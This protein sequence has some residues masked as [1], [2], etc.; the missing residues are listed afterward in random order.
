[1]LIVIQLAH[2]RKLLTVFL[3]YGRMLM[4][5]SRRSMPMPGCRTWNVP[6]IFSSG[7]LISSTVSR[8]LITNIGCWSSSGSVSLVGT[9][10]ENM[11]ATASGMRRNLFSLSQ[12]L[13]VS[14]SSFPPPRAASRDCWWQARLFEMLDPAMNAENKKTPT[15]TLISTGGS[16]SGPAFVATSNSSPD[17]HTVTELEQLSLEAI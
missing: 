2:K 5:S 12:I 3:F 10:S 9:P 8:T 11:K 1:M 14:L 15:Y 6:E 13:G 17:F 4:E 7:A 16:S